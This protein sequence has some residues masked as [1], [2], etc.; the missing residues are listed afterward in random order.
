MWL[1]DF[2]TKVGNTSAATERITHA[3]NLKQDIFSFLW[4]DVGTLG[5]L[6]NTT[7]TYLPVPMVLHTL[8]IDGLWAGWE[9]RRDKMITYSFDNASTKFVSDQGFFTSL[10]YS[11]WNPA[12]QYTS[13]AGSCLGNGD[14]WCKRGDFHGPGLYTGEIMHILKGLFKSG[15]KEKAWDMLSSYS[16]LQNAPIW[17]ESLNFDAAT[18]SNVGV[19]AVSYIDGA[20]GFSEV[21]I[22]GL[23]GLSTDTCFGTTIWPHIPS[24]FGETYLTNIHVQSHVIDVHINGQDSTYMVDVCVS[25]DNSSSDHYRI[26]L[27]TDAPKTMILLVQNLVD[28]DYYLI[29][30]GNN[31]GS[32]VVNNNRGYFIIPNW[33]GLHKV[34]IRNYL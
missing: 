9:S 33:E 1:A 18:I 27:G 29:I 3:N 34:E 28:D 20:I 2:Y 23:F 21:L 24:G 14:H 16:Y 19:T 26:Q 4:H 6:G 22:Q 30:D 17:K 15:Y 7:T 31:V 8:D 5:T 11:W 12:T 10:P 32:F 25:C 13:D